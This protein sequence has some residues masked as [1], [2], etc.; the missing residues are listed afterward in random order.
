MPDRLC[1][2]VFPDVPTHF[3]HCPAGIFVLRYCLAAVA[4][5]ISCLLPLSPNAFVRDDVRLA[6]QAFADLVEE[7]ALTFFC[8]FKDFAIGDA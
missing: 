7:N 5:A 6:P 1:K 3:N 8:Y 4:Q 2:G